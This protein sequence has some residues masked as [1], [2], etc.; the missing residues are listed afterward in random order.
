MALK[1]TRR[2][3]SISGPTYDRLKKYCQL[4]HQSMSQAVEFMIADRINVIL[5]PK[6]KHDVLKAGDRSQA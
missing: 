5:D 3:I 1:Q 4:T 2:S 6:M